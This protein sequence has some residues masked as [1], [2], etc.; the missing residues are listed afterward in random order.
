MFACIVF[1][2]LQDNLMG[3]SAE[4]HPDMDMLTCPPHLLPSFQIQFSVEVQSMAP[5]SELDRSWSKPQ[6]HL[7]LVIWSMTPFLSYA[8]CLIKTF[9]D[10]AA[11]MFVHQASFNNRDSGFPQLRGDN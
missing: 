10:F 8:S 2:V 4:E 1:L 5:T 9:V 7:L 3:F 6:P 11:Q